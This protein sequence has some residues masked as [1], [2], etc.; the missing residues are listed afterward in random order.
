VHEILLTILL[1]IGSIVGAMV[2]AG[3]IF[4]IAILMTGK[5]PSLKEIFR[6]IK[7]G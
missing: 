2:A 7:T 3:R 4:R 6:W 1:L 5:T